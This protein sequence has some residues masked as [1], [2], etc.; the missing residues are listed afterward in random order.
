MKDDK[1]KFMGEYPVALGIIRLALPAMLGMAVQML[2]NLTDTYFIGQTNDPLIVAGISLAS[3]LFFIIQALGNMFAVGSAS[4]IS[5]QLGAGKVDK[6]R[7][8]SAVA[9]Y[10]TIATGLIITLVLL[11]FKDSVL[12]SVGT[13]PDTWGHAN[14]Y[15]TVIVW[16]SVPMAANIAM[17]GL[18]RSEGATLQ[19]TIGMSIGLIINVILDPIFILGFRLNAAGAA[20]A[21]VIGHLCSSVYYLR[22]F[23]AKRSLLSIAPADF[24]PSGAIYA[25]TFKIGA[26][27]A[28]SQIVMSGSMVLSN[29]I[30]SG[31]GGILKE[32]GDILVA[33]IGVY[34]R[35]GSLCLSL[36]MG[37]TMGYQ[38]FAG[39]NYG[40][41]KYKRL[42]KGLWITT[43]YA[44]GLA[45][46]F[47]LI[48]RFFGQ[49][50]IRF[51]ID[52][53]ATVLAGNMLLQALVWAMPFVG[54]QLTLT[55][56]FQALGKSLNAMIITLGRQCLFYIP[57][58]F[59]LPRIFGLNGFV[60]AQPVADI[61]TTIIAVLLSVNFLKHMYQMIRQ[62]PAAG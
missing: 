58:L 44:T 40:A 53:N 41:E 7:E 34:M 19:A 48:F 62:Q 54:L 12:G 51:F 24:K 37:L 50:L 45:C 21:T 5:R 52:D 29:M 35:V 3:P 6:A 56:T 57:L 23:I 59:T 25:E 9:F 26:P 28:L 11:V 22:H 60:F 17:G 61:L 49:A 20:W 36:L 8:T 15:F 43:A 18:L 31:F 13:S 16:F 1:L 55:V 4:V 10:T 47:A 2:Y 39:F 27:S 38:P 14:D 33:G 46:A 42:V 30:A 32:G